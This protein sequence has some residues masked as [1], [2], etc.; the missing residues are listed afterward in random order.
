MVVRWQIRTLTSKE[1][2]CS[3]GS[4]SR[5][6]S[7]NLRR[8]V[9]NANSS[10]T[11]IKQTK[12]NK[13]IINTLKME[14]TEL[15]KKYDTELNLL[16]LS[17]STR[18]YYKSAVNKFTSECTRAYRI[19]EFELKAY[20]SEF[21]LRYSDSYFNVMGSALVILYSKV[22]KQRKMD[23]FK[24]I[25]TKKTFKDI[26]TREELIYMLKNTK[27]IKHKTIILFLFSTGV[28]IGELLQL[29]I[30]D[31]DLDRNRIFIQRQKNQV[32]SYINLHPLLK[33]YLTV[34]FIHYKLSV[35]L[36]GGDKP[37]ST[38]SVRKIINKSSTGLNKNIYPHLFRSTH[39]TLTTNNENVFVAQ[40]FAGH[41][42]LK[43]TLHYYQPNIENSYNP[44]NELSV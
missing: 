9:R 10:L 23:W 19:T 30:H 7:W 29:K 36:F 18:S 2:Q 12:H 26:I 5:P 6:L 38:T 44:L 34:Y 24:P 13:L 21:R 14:L 11:Y 27:N 4:Y 37:Y 25:P 40:Y 22:L 32:N 3:D 42:S 20:L 35:Y 17:E 15:L 41:K 33:K 28:R 1:N 8:L 16:P 43:S 31:V 39:I